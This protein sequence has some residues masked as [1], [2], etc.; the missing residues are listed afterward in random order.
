MALQAHPEID[1]R[2]HQVSFTSIHC[3][4]S[5]LPVS[6]HVF[7]TAA[8]KAV[9]LKPSESPPELSFEEL[10]HE[11]SQCKPA[12]TPHPGTRP[13]PFLHRPAPKIAIISAAAF[14]LG[15]KDAEASGVLHIEDIHQEIAATQSRSA[16][17][18][19]E[20]QKPVQTVEELV[21]P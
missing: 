19:K 14:K 12:T 16:Q 11:L 3:T 18:A 9:R 10:C 4:Q 17:L 7:G 1:W 20:N 5:C 8:P 6:I 15:Q 2:S 13:R 21:P